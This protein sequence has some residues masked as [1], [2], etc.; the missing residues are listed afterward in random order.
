MG[1]ILDTINGHLRL[2]EELGAGE[3]ASAEDA[4]DSL[5]SLNSMLSS[6]SIQRDLV[7]TETTD[8]VTLTGSQ[9]AYTVGSGGDLNI[10][11]PVRVKYITV[12]NGGDGE[13]LELTQEQYIAISQKDT[14]GTPNAYWY[15]GNYPLGNLYL[16]PTPDSAYSMTIYSEKPLSEY[17]AV[18]DTL[19]APEGWER[20]FRYNLAVER[21]PEY[22]KQPSATVMRI[23]IQSKNAI[24]NACAET[25][26]LVV[27]D[28]L[29]NMQFFDIN[30]GY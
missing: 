17:S 2:L 12:N 25:E 8:T 30:R 11:R 24:R 5:F 20:A 14:Q 13:L 10:T 26:K 9:A 16:Y 28:T 29:N 18:T 22:G 15:D 3:T 23:A 4:Q 27:D 7:F 1:T 6:W 19:V 21:A